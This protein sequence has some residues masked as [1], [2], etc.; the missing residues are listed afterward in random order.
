MSV[1]RDN[2][3]YGDALADSVSLFG[4]GPSRPVVGSRYGSAGAIHANPIQLKEV[5]F[6]R[7][8]P[9]RERELCLV[10]LVRVFAG[11]LRLVTAGH[12]GPAGT[13]V[14]GKAVAR[15]TKAKA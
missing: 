1:Y 5:I 7:P 2:A 6:A 10:F 3:A 12:L 4:Q 8:I 9:A 11:S 13:D 15:A 14:P